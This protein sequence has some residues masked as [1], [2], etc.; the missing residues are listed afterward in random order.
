MKKIAIDDATRQLLSKS[1]RYLR[2]TLP[3]D[4]KQIELNRTFPPSFNF[5]EDLTV[6]L[7]KK[8]QASSKETLLH[9]SHSKDNV[10]NLV[11]DIKDIHQSISNCQQCFLGKQR[12][13]S[14]ALPSIKEI[15]KVKTFV[16]VDNVSYYDQARGQYLMDATG[17]LIKDI[18]KA[19][20]LS[21]EQVYITAL[22]KC[23]QTTEFGDRIDE[24]AV[25]QDHL[26]RELYY[27]KPQLI[28]AFGETTFDILNASLKKKDASGKNHLD[29][30]A[31]FEKMRGR[32]LDY[33]DYDIVFTHHPRE[34][35]RNISLKKETWQDLKPL[36]TRLEKM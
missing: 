36:L 11:E 10:S 3:P 22:I 34:M 26:K 9:S 31:S 5:L 14:L 33:L 8:N 13:D 18:L 19:L 4:V 6:T 15:E 16:L 27:F 29:K 23:T 1:Y 32:M 20:K 30:N 12:G 24:V 7:E 35:M 21:A 2:D 28:I 25:C 17:T